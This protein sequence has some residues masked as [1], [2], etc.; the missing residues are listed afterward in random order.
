[1]RKGGDLKELLYLAR[2]IKEAS[3]K[4]YIL[5]RSFYDLGS[6]NYE[7]GSRKGDYE[8][9]DRVL[10]VVAEI[11]RYYEHIK[12]FENGVHGDIRAY[13]DI[14]V[15]FQNNVIDSRI[16][17]DK[18]AAVRDEIARQEREDLLHND[19]HAGTALERK[20]NA[21]V[22]DLETSLRRLETQLDTVVEPRLREF[23]N[24]V[25]HILYCEKLTSIIRTTEGLT[26]VLADA[27]PTDDFI[28]HTITFLWID[29]KINRTRTIA[30]KLSDFITGRI[31][32]MGLLVPLEDAAGLTKERRAESLAEIGR[33]FDG[34]LAVELEQKSP[35]PQPAAAV[36][37][38]RRLEAVRISAQIKSLLDNLCYINVC[39]PSLYLPQYRDYRDLAKSGRS[40]YR[41]HVPGSGEV[42]LHTVSDYHTNSLMAVFTWVKREIR[43]DIAQLAH[44]RPLISALPECDRFVRIYCTALF[45][46]S[47]AGNQGESMVLG[48]ERH[49]IPVGLARDLFAAIRDGCELIDAAFDAAVTAIAL[50]R[51]PEAETLGKKLLIM[52]DSFSDAKSK[53]T[54]WLGRLHVEE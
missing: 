50:E 6:I 30:M 46:S 16:I 9:R 22:A 40:R 51:G 31:E 42:T 45:V 23:L 10:E 35:S 39:K 11:N 38:G 48:E 25:N 18:I 14:P 2:T 27:T 53:I 20:K 7:K 4:K 34:L 15:F 41:F 32:Q 37:E 47:I 52:R 49:Y 8:I 29:R 5:A 28:R 19:K 12:L 13:E 3:E 54:H 44:L 21:Y 17:D 26:K 33:Q 36:E 43:R 24:D 1:M